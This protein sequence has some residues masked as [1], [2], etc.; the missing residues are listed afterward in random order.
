LFGKDGFEYPGYYNNYEIGETI[1]NIEVIDLKNASKN[2]KL[3]IVWNAQIIGNDIFNEDNYAYLIDQ[4]F[5]ISTFI[6]KQI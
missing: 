5:E 3:K 1:W 4:I 2:N 6:P